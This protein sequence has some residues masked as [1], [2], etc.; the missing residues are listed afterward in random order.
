MSDAC[1]HS[2]AAKLVANDLPA[3]LRVPLAGAGEREA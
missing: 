2:I 1:P 3:H